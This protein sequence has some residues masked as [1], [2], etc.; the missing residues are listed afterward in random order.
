MDPMLK[1][2]DGDLSATTS[3]LEDQDK[4]MGGQNEGNMQENPLVHDLG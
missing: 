4:Y 3:S 2:C 1:I